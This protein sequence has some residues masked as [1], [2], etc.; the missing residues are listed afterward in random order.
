[1]VYSLAAKGAGVEGYA[2]TDWDILDVPVEMVS[3]RAEFAA[4]DKVHPSSLKE[5]VARMERGYWMNPA[6]LPK[7][8]L[9]ACGSRILPDILPR[10]TVSP[11]FR[12]LVE[13]FEPDIH[14]FAPV[15]I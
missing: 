11:R 2:E 8:V 15:E 7:K 9:W 10:F 1:M 6:T 3:R 12:D 13:Q 5:N 14:Q 4:P